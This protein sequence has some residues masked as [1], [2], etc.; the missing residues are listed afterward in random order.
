MRLFIGIPLAP[1]VIEALDR[2]VRGLQTP[3][4]GLRWT[5]AATWHITLQFLGATTPSQVDCLMAGLAR[6]ES[7]P[8]PVVLDG[9]GFFDRAGVYFAGINVSTELRQ[10]QKQVVSATSPCGFTAEE[11]PCH[12][13]VTL[14]RAKGDDRASTLKRLQA[15]TNHQ[16]EF[17]SFMAT[18]FVLYEAFL[19]TERSRYE[20]RARFPLG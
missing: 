15:K 18:E 2:M 3:G 8:V 14:A 11:R 13:H 20:V 10:L 12:P 5:L 16:V 6:I 4:D 9:T 7:T 1:G 17:P 19:G